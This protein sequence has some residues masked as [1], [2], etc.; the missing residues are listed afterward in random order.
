MNRTRSIS[1]SGH[2]QYFFD[3][4]TNESN[5]PPNVMYSMSAS[6]ACPLVVLRDVTERE[7]SPPSVSPSIISPTSPATKRQSLSRFAKRT[8]KHLPSPVLPNTPLPTHNKPHMIFDQFEEHKISVMI[9]DREQNFTPHGSVLN[10]A[11]YQYPSAINE[12]TDEDVEG[13][14]DE[15]DDEYVDVGYN[16]DKTPVVTDVMGEC[17]KDDVNGEMSHSDESVFSESS[18]VRSKSMANIKTDKF[19]KSGNLSL[20]KKGKNSEGKRKKSLRLDSISVQGKQRSSTSKQGIF[21]CFIL[22]FFLC[23]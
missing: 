10:A 22:S 14:D 21:C 9:E 15:T 11:S 13:A 20:K 5:K 8:E 18:E 6:A 1:P 19:K 23:F 4:N 7:F 2:E 12:I 17:F 16:E 3:E